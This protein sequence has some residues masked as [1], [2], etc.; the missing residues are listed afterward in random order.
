MCLQDPGIP[1]NASEQYDVISEYL[2]WYQGK[3]AQAR[4]FHCLNLSHPEA[5]GAEMIAL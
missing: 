5:E 1:L 4:I 2:L 3:S